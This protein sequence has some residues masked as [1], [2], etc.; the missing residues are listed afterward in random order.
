MFLKVF[1][2]FAF[3]QHV[4][5]FISVLLALLPVVLCDLPCSIFLLFS[6][7]LPFILALFCSHWLSPPSQRGSVSVSFPVSISLPAPQLF[8]LFPVPSGLSSAPSTIHCLLFFLSLSSPFL[9]SLEVNNRENRTWSRRGMLQPRMMCLRHAKYCLTSVSPDCFHL[10]GRA[11]PT[12]SSTD[13]VFDVSCHTIC[14]YTW[15]IPAFCFAQVEGQKLCSGD[16]VEC[17]HHFQLSFPRHVL[18]FSS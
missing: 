17:T 7:F 6:G 16:E 3:P 13:T 5:A 8:L 10:A 15:E 9:P 18:H 14:H 2:L 11:E 12:S 4:P 1:S